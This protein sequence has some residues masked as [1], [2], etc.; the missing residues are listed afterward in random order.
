[1][2]SVDKALLQFLDRPQNVAAAAAGAFLLLL[3]VLYRQQ[4]LFTLRFIGKS[5]YRNLLR[6]LLTGLATMVLVFV[7]T[8]VWS[9]FALIDK[10]TEEKSK[11]FKSIVTER[12]QL[13]SQMPYAYASSLVTGA[14]TEPGDYR[15]NPDRDAM[16][17]QFWVGSID[18][19][20]V[21]RE[22][23]VFFFCMEP[24]KVL[25]MMDGVDEFTEPERAEVER[26]CKEVEKDPRKVVLGADRLRALNKQVG[27]RFTA[28]GIQSYKDIDFEVEVVGTFPEGRYNQSG[29]M[30][31]EYFNRTLDDYERKRGAKHP[32]A[33][34]SLNLVWLRVPDRA[35]FQRVADQVENR[36][37]Y[38]APAV[39]CEMASSAIAS[40]LEPY[41]DLFWGMRWLFVPAV[42]AT[43]ALVI[44][45][46]ISIGV[47]ERR[48][49]MAILKVLGFSPGRIL[50]LVIAEALTVGVVCGLISAGATWYVVDHLM[51]GVKFP[52]AFF[53]AF[54]VPA[55]AWWWGAAIGG[56][57]A[58]AGS[59]LPA[60]SAR[61]VRVSEVFAKIA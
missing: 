49:E 39:K 42:L 54:L 56:L 58:L 36:G 30:N 11:D 17:W 14:A 41:R 5:L 59:L 48:T 53:P 19:V 1:M 44:A 60:W 52:I 45:N 29:V 33:E 35:V 50:A 24:D 28:R 9:V 55:D 12:W 26:L 10:V 47:R 2:N 13:P 61:S 27:E 51:G 25:K 22:S 37:M 15:V 43:I 3:V 21:T 34:K 18:P 7:V 8:L 4:F 40:F 38:T 32:L 46:A 31:R 57:T 16:T 23:F 20:K 6:T